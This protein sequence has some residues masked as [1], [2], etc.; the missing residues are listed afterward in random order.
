MVVRNFW[1]LFSPSVYIAFKIPFSLTNGLNFAIS[2]SINSIEYICTYIFDNQ[3]F[4]S[5]P[6][7]PDSLHIAKEDNK[8]ESAE[9]SKKPSSDTT[10]YIPAIKL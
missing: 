7:N 1:K 3:M 5:S 2:F 4:K 9:F 10:G 8:N 6:P